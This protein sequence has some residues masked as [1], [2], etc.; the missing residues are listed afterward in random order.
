VADG[1]W[2]LE[3]LYEH[4][5]ALTAEQDLRH[6][7]RYDAQIKALDAALLAAEKAVDAALKAAEKAVTKAEI[8]AEKRFESVNEFRGTLAD[9][10]AQ[11]MSRTEVTALLAAVDARLA[12]MSEKIDANTLRVEKMASAGGGMK[13]GWQLLVGAVALI[14]T[15]VGLYLALRR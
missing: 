2:T 10:A 12:A 3:T 15:V 13:E 4:F 14:A 7:Q 5:T 11:L 6:Q 1:G 8:A 9:Q